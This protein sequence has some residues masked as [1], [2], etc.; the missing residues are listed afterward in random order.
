MRISDWSS[1]VCSSDLVNDRYG[2]AAGDEALR[3]LGAWI[4]ETV[5][6]RGIVGRSGGDEFTI[7][8]DADATEAEAMLQRLRDRIEPITVF[9]QTFGFNI[10]SG[11]CQAGDGAS[12]LEQLIHDADQAL[13]RAKHEGRDRV[14]RADDAAAAPAP[15]AGLVVVGSGI[16][17]GRHATER[18]LSEIREAQVVFCLADPF[19]L[20]MI[21]GLRPDA[22]NLGRRSEARR[23]GKEWVSTCK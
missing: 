1:D 2:H 4:R 9:G 5:D 14:V 11:V 12:T 7:L 8:L 13:Y 3:S 22:I 17:F 21:Q 19:A 23:V 6:G 15:A 10:S 18:C 20:A 16:Q